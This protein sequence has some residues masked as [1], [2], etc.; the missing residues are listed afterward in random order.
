MSPLV[1]EA[2]APDI[3]ELACIVLYLYSASLVALIHCIFNIGLRAR[4]R[5]LSP[6]QEVGERRRI[7]VINYGDMG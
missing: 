2:L 3:A 7:V 5:V 6:M 1:D 4:A